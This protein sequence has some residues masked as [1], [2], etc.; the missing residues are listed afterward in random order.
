MPTGICIDPRDNSILVT[1]RMNGRVLRFPAE[2]GKEGEE[3]VGAQQ[4]L[5]RPWGVCQGKDGTIYV[6]DE[7]AAV[8]LR[9]DAPLPLP[10]SRQHSPPDTA[11]DAVQSAPTDEVLEVSQDPSQ[12]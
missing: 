3:L 1:D 11:M 7:R 10:C 12:L 2:G 5:S 9:V 8:V 6:S 4:Q